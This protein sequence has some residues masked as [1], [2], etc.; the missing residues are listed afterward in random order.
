MAAFGIDIKR[1]R[2]WRG[3]R[4]GV[5]GWGH[6]SAWLAKNN[7]SWSRACMRDWGEHGTGGGEKGGEKKERKG[8]N[9][10]P[11]QAGWQQRPLCFDGVVWIVAALSRHQ[12]KLRK[13]NAKG[14]G[15]GG[16]GGWR[17]R[18]KDDERGKYMAKVLEG[19]WEQP[20]EGHAAKP[21]PGRKDAP[22]H[23]SG[24][25]GAQGARGCTG[26]AMLGCAS[27]AELSV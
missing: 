21:A 6:G 25:G 3:W 22:E 26:C 10:K 11:Q 7:R 17:S 27:A 2:G 24:P 14:Q 4:T 8:K 1:P 23:G 15:V 13:R 20:T 5:L 16:G 12:P 9:P 19:L 18:R